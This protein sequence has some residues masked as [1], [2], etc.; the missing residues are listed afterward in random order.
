VE[1]AELEALAQQAANGDR[2][3][4][5]SI[6]AYLSDLIVRYVEY[7]VTDQQVANWIVDEIFA[8]AWD[9][10]P[11]RAAEVASSGAA[12]PSIPLEHWFLRVSRNAVI[13]YY[14]AHPGA[15]GR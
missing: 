5:A 8:M 6:R 2:A 11:A 3:A 1:P 13:R 15:I 12:E 7:K 9:S 10:M 4:F 14:R